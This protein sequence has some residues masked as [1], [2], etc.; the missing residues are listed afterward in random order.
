MKTLI[1]FSEL[2]QDLQFLVVDGDYSRFHG[3]NVNSIEHHE[4]EQE[5]IEWCFET[6]TGNKKNPNWSTDI[7]IVENKDWDKIAVVN[8]LS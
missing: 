1:F 6:E 8:F 5:F 7:S 4:F 3:I 2:E